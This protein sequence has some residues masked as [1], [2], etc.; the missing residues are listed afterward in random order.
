[1]GDILGHFAHSSKQNI[2][3]CQ[4]FPHYASLLR[5]KPTLK[6][7]DVTVVGKMHQVT[8]EQRRSPGDSGR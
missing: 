8:S 4:P 5:S 2:F 7:A 1:M 6:K 3:H